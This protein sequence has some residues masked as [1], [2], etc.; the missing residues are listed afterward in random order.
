M[1]ANVARHLS[2]S[3]RMAHVYAVFQTQRFHER[4]KIVGISIHLVAVPR[5]AGSAVAAPVVR[6]AAISTGC[7]K[8]HLVL[9]RVGAERPAV[10]EYD[11]LPRTPV[12]VVN[13]RA[14]SG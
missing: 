11:R 5:L 12:L 4:R 7:Q 14:V 3:R 2:T 1:A 10:A 9:P 8:Q 13:L 6:N